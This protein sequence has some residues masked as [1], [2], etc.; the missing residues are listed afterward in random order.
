MPSARRLLAA[1]LLALAPRPGYG[2]VYFAAPN[3]RDGNTAA[4]PQEPL[5]LSG[6]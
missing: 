1:P 2:R 4:S 5:S 6:C 3:G